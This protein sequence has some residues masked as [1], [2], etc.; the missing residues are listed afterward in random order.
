MV[1]K[2]KRFYCVVC[3]GIQE[4][5]THSA[6][7]RFAAFGFLFREQHDLHLP[8][9]ICQKCCKQLENPYEIVLPD[10]NI[11]RAVHI[12]SRHLAHLD[13]RPRGLLA[14]DPIPK[15]TNIPYP[16]KL[17]YQPELEKFKQKFGY[18]LSREWAKGGI[19]YA[20]TQTILFG[21]FARASPRSCAHFINCAKG[22]KKVRANCGW[23]E[24]TVDASFR[25]HY[26]DLEIPPTSG[27]FK[28]GYPC[29]YV[30]AEQGLQPGEEFLVA[31]YGGFFWDRMKREQCGIVPVARPVAL[32]QHMTKVLDGRVNTE[33]TNRRGLKRARSE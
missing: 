13:G 8:Q 21:Q 1:R 2:K 16:G 18:E 29:I 19:K 28:C 17:V 12:T 4:A 26:P 31:K 3:L 14:L 23:R 33:E 15:G 25:E 5:A 20:H 7:S 6:P 11:A 32:N 9:R 27:D 10:G 22:L 30:K 24:A